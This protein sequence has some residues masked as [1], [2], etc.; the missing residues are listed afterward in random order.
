MG[1]FVFVLV[2]V[3]VLVIDLL[4]FPPK[5]GIEHEDEDD[6]E[7]DWDRIEDDKRKKFMVRNDAVGRGLPRISADGC[8]RGGRRPKSKVQSPKS[9]VQSP[10]SEVRGPSLDEACYYL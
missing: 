5:N 6:D 2:L 10:R 1:A 4:S 8:G 3:L 7:D 9:K